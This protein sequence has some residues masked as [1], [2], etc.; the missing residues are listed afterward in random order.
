MMTAVTLMSSDA[1]VMTFSDRRT[2]LNYSM[3]T[4]FLGSAPLMMYHNLTPLVLWL[5]C[6]CYILV[7][8]Y[9][10]VYHYSATPLLLIYL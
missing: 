4:Y 8:L 6:L 2:K 1:Y 5:C 10:H 9:H 7:M 3:L